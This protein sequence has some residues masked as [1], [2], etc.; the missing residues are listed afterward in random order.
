MNLLNDM[1]Y[2]NKYF[3]KREKLL[4]IFIL[5]GISIVLII[6]LFFCPKTESLAN[7]ILNIISGVVGSVST[8]LVQKIYR[9][10]PNGLNDNHKEQ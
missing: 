3:F 1:W 5:G 6:L 2:N 4:L 8:I 9:H 10:D 7:G